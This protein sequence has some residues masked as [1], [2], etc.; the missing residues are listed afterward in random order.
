MIQEDFTSLYMGEMM[1][2][3]NL[4]NTIKNFF[5]VLFF[6]ES[7]KL[8]W[9][10]LLFIGFLFVIIW[11]VR[12][13]YKSIKAIQNTTRNE[14]FRMLIFF[15]VYTIAMIS[16]P[17]LN[18]AEAGVAS[19][20]IT[21]SVTGIITYM[22]EASSKSSQ[23]KIIEDIGTHN[24]GLQEKYIEEVTK[25]KEDYK[26]RL[27]DLEDKLYQLENNLENIKD[28]QEQVLVKVDTNSDY[29]IENQVKTLKLIGQIKRSSKF[30]NNSLRRRAKGR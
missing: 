9:G 19:I 24:K 30:K 20:I 23:K 21:I 8:D 11:I 7:G 27:K 10:V 5:V 25:L 16:M 14:Q 22:Q 1:F 6:T 18:S 15:I 3:D 26:D 13:G 17:F 2:L 12:Q 4:Y 28:K 29:L